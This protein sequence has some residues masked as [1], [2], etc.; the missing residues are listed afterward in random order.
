MFAFNNVYHL[1][2]R[3]PG[4]AADQI[5]LQWLRTHG[6]SSWK[7]GDP[8]ENGVRDV[9]VLSRDEL[10]AHVARV[11][12]SFVLDESNHSAAPAE[13]VIAQRTFDL[14]SEGTKAD[15]IRA[16][17][18]SGLG[19]FGSRQVLDVSLNS[20]GKGDEISGISWTASVS[21]DS[22][23][24]RFRILGESV[25]EAPSLE[26]PRRRSTG[27]EP[28]IIAN[29]WLAT[30]EIHSPYL[31]KQQADSWTTGPLT[32]RQKA[33]NIFSNVLK[34]YKYDGSIRNISEFT[35]R[36]TLVR[37]GNNYAGI[38]DEWAVV[39][40]SYLRAIGIESRLKFMIWTQN[41][42][43]VG[44]ACL[45]FNDGGRWTH[46][47]ALW[48]AF[49]NPG[50]YRQSGAQN[51][52]VMDADF[53]TDSRSTAPAWGVPDLTGDGK[54]YPY[55]DFAINPSYPGNSRAGYSY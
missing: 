15:A 18:R 32:V 55:G 45:E 41:G 9:I 4:L 3:H 21:H 23:V 14:L 50:R 7:E 11:R 1:F 52:T 35:W 46:M 37:E 19:A 54:L 16:V 51:L 31:F 40:I 20:E 47:D 44:H 53:P 49:D 10:S 5:F 12:H 42:Q 6:A 38:C 25:S 17:V 33:F 2:A 48:S 29:E 30:N 13:V 24:K 39:Q 28:V 34:L 26:L 43:G 8:D 27:G 22:H 36:D